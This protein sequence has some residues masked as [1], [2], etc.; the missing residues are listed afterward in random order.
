ME[1][2]GTAVPDCIDFSQLQLDL[3]HGQKI[4]D[5]LKGPIEAKV[6][7]S[8]GRR[9]AAA[10]NRRPLFRAVFCEGESAQTPGLSDMR[11]ITT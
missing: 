3:H 8:R 1:D 2:Q 9:Q 11:K 6:S 10:L 7:W 5:A 4:R